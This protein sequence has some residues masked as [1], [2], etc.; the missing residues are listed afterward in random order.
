MNALSKPVILIVDPDALSLT[1]ISAILHCSE[2]EV[3]CAQDREAALRGAETL[4]LDLIVCD[5]RIDN[6]RA[7]EL[8]AELRSIPDRHDVPVMYMSTHQ[9]PDIIHRP[10]ESGAA[11]HLRKPIDP[12]VLLE[13]VDKALWQLPVINRHVNDPHTT[14]TPK[15]G[16]VNSI[17]T[18]TATFT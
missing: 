9:L 1:A 13:L 10:H 11:Y 2:Y 14:P 3:H 5:D 15:L 16:Q 17:T 7:V 18:P 12:K 4:E 8:I 6:G